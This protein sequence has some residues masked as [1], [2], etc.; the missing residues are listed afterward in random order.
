MQVFFYTDVKF[1][2]HK[3]SD[4]DGYYVLSGELPPM[5]SSVESKLGE[6]SLVPRPSLAPVFDR[7]QYVKTEPEGSFFCILQAIKNQ[8]AQ[9]LHTASDQKPE[10]GKAWE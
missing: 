4:S 10:P 9:F 5:I 1:H 3:A 7:L 8:K 6:S 2:P